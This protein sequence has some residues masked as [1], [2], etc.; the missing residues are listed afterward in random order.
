MTAAQGQRPTRYSADMHS[1]DVLYDT[2]K[3]DVYRYALYLTQNT[4]EAEDLYQETWF[5]VVKYIHKLEKVRNAKAWIMTIESNIFKDNLRKKRVRKS[6]PVSLDALGDHTPLYPDSH[7]RRTEFQ[8]TL[9]V[10]LLDLPARQRQVFVL[11][12]MEGY[13]LER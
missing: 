6:G 7:S 2:Y 11:K 10:M 3:A 4:G 5:R 9:D 13:P 1:F 8:L 12:A